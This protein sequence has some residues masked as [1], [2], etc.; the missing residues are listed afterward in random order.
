MIKTQAA[1]DGDSPACSVCGRKA[2]DALAVYTCGW[3][4][5]RWAVVC[6][7]C[8]TETCTRC[9]YRPTELV[10]DQAVC[11]TCAEE[12]NAE[13]QF[14][15]YDGTELVFG[16]VPSTFPSLLLCAADVPLE[17]LKVGQHTLVRRSGHVYKVIRTK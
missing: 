1:T 13:L 12:L 9:W 3:P 2:S 15:V 10:G 6:D 14:N 7:D 4:G 8:A 11:P 5:R 16:N 17:A